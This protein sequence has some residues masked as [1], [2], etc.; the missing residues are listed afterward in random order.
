VRGGGKCTMG[1]ERESHVVE[2]LVF[3]WKL[4]GPAFGGCL[5]L[6]SLLSK[7]VPVVSV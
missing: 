6:R 3:E 1:W 2:S 7:S 4:Y 5:L